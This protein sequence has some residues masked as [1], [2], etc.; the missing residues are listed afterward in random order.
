MQIDRHKGQRQFESPQFVAV[1][2]VSGDVAVSDSV[3]NC[4]KVILAIL[5]F[6]TASAQ[7]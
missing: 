7:E 3:K 6:K 5:R 2:P 1:S 4:V